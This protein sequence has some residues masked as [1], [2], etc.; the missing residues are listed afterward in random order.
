MKGQGRDTS[1]VLGAAVAVSTAWQLQHLSRG[2][3]ACPATP[4]APEEW[5]LPAD[6]KLLLFGPH[7]QQG[8]MQ[9]EQLLTCSSS[10]PHT[11]EPHPSP[12]WGADTAKGQIPSFS[13]TNPSQL[14]SSRS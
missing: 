10:P 9:W 12:A 4:S 14:P 5:T 7:P 8:Q 1:A 2:S 11:S 6:N 13:T 3:S